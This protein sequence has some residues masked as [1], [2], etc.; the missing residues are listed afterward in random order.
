MPREVQQVT[1]VK[2]GHFDDHKFCSDGVLQLRIDVG[3]GVLRFVRAS[4]AAAGRRR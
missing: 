3:P 4:C 1:R 2:R